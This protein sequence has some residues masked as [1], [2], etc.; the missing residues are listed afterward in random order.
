MRAVGQ[1]RGL[2]IDETNVAAQRD[3]SFDQEVDS[4]IRAAGEKENLVIDSRTAF[5]FIPQSFKVFLK[6]EPH[7]AAKRT[8]V[9]II[10]QGRLAQD[11]SSGNEVHQKLLTRTEND[12]ER[13]LKT[14]GFDYLDEKQFDLVINTADHPLEEVVKIILEKYQE[15][16]KR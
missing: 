2:S 1:R 4:E 13:Y 7:V 6:L 10:N 3:P 11:A 9:Q 8:F 14:Y 12:R 16:L 5:H 15:W